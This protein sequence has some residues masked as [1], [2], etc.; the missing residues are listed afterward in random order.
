LKLEKYL[1]CLIVEITI[2]KNWWERKKNLEKSCTAMK[3][4]QSAELMVVLP[5]EPFAQLDVARKITSLALA[6]RLGWLEAE[7]ER[8]RAQLAEAED[9]RERVEQLNAA[10]A[11]ATGCLRRAEEEK[12][13]LISFLPVEAAV[14][15]AERYPI[16]S[17]S[18]TTEPYQR[19]V[20]ALA[21]SQILRI[22][23]GL[24][25]GLAS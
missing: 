3:L 21:A 20:A 2:N 15:R 9:L 22:I 5:D 8:L 12:V 11:V 13:P 24:R 10:L 16:L 23:Q 25:H 7:A 14:L 19:L 6:S 1:Q 18:R 4:R 17:T